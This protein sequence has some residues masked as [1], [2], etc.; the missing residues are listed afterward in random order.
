MATWII[1]RDTSRYR[2]L[3]LSD[4]KKL[5]VLSMLKKPT[6]VKT[7]WR[8]LEVEY[9]VDEYEKNELIGDFPGLYYYPA[10]SEKGIETLSPLIASQTEFL[11]LKCNGV[12]YYI[13]HIIN[14]VTCLDHAQSEIVYHRKKNIPIGV[15]KYFFDCEQLRE[16]HIFRLQEDRLVNVFV[17]DKFKSLVEEHNLK[18]FV[19]EK[20]DSNC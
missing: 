17:S 14:V 1:T 7:D 11:P 5:K 16:Q 2:T 3:I 19:F 4:T 12:A 18:G 9:S 6:E 8:P 20:I 10:L 15:E 13:V